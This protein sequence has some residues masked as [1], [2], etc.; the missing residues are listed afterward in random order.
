MNP[1]Q[2]SL[3]DIDK[4]LDRLYAEIRV[5]DAQKETLVAGSLIPTLRDTT[6]TW[7]TSPEVNLVCNPVSEPLKKALLERTGWH[8]SL[9]LT[10]GSWLVSLSMDDG[11][12]T[13]FIEDD[14]LNGNPHFEETIATCLRE[15][16]ATTGIKIIAA[17]FTQKIEGLQAQVERLTLMQ[18]HAEKL[19][20]GK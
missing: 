15:V 11:D 6:W 10:L 3:S 16:A 1:D 4:E 19:L 12:V 7:N 8:G 20:I 18:E 9:E 14:R 13:M 5:L 17:D 2:L